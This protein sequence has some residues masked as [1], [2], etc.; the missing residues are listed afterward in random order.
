[1][2]EPEAPRARTRGG[3]AKTQ[4]VIADGERV[5]AIHV[6]RRTIALGGV[7]LLLLSTLYFGATG[8][9]FFRDGLLKAAEERQ[10]A[11]IASQNV[12]EAREVEAAAIHEVQISAYEGQ[13]AALRDKVGK[14][15]SEI[16]TLNKTRSK[17]SAGVDEKVRSLLDR[18]K[19]LEARQKALAKI[20]EAAR[21]AGL[22]VTIPPP[23]PAKPKP[24]KGRKAALDPEVTGSI[25]PAVAKPS[26]QF[27]DMGLRSP[28]PMPP[29][30]VPRLDPLEDKIVAMA[31]D[32]DAL[33]GGLM[34]GVTKRTQKIDAA[35]RKLGRRVPPAPS[36][37]GGP[38][39]PAPKGTISSPASFK[40][41]V[42]TLTNQFDR[43]AKLRQIALALPLKRP[44]EDADIS[45]GFGTRRDPF[46][47]RL[48]THT[49]I[50]FR[51]MSG[52]PARTVNAGKVVAAAFNGGYGNCVDVDHGNG[53]ITRYGHL[54]SISVKVGERVVAGQKIGTVGSTGRS[55]GPH[56][57][58]EIR[59]DG[60]PIDPMIYLRA[61]QEIN[62]LL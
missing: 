30:V 16:E 32:Q 41:D 58:Y 31:A 19:E 42:A 26:V 49:G 60:E 5:R 37:M 2:P 36:G 52:L 20:A 54:R 56:L 29:I 40:A 18:Q 28:Q 24:A 27:A 57:H 15:N 8:Y 21:R 4:I 45:S 47:G 9:L 13:V 50:D 55:T 11:I 62:R 48:A 17:E 14:L 35:L 61:G 59:I 25:S 33:V 10:N 53:V 38:F 44:L 39:V 7:C 34:A 12:R 23:A 6:R 3:K 22:D 1:M 51:A 46:L 43:L